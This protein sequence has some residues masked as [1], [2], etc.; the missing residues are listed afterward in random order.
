MSER[1]WLAGR[2][3]RLN[4][5]QRIA[6]VDLA[7]GLAV[8]GMFAAHLLWID[9][10][11]EWTDAATWVAVVDGR[12]SILFATLAGVSIGLVTGARTPLRGSALK[13]ARVRLAV[14]ALLLWLLG[15]LLILT[16]VPVYVILP[17]Y[18]LLFFLAILLVRLGARTLLSLSALLA[19]VMPVV[20]VALDELPLWN[21]M[22]GSTLSLAI[23]WHY[24]FTTWIAFLVAGLGVARAGIQRLSVQLWMLGAGVALAVVGYGADAATGAAEADER[25]SYLGALWTARP[26]STGL[27]EVVG[28]GGFALAVIGAAL[29][30]CRTVLVW[31]VLPLRA[32]G[33]MPLTA[34]TA[35]LLVWAAIASDVLGDAG[36]LAGFRDLQPF[37]PLTLTTVALCTAWALLVGRGPLEWAIDR[38][39]RW[40]ARRVDA[41]ERSAV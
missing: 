19:L 13:T 1:G 10:S 27:L 5:P 31:I 41:Q 15:L 2:W 35:Q 12:S 32:V 30:L 16:G 23:G 7:R 28:S 9:D 24:P 40:A 33:A 3:A 29:L 26:H 11:F 34:Y 17:A 6:G 36:D 20:Q 18:A 4:G 8:L 39:A 21:T 22:S 25:S 14:R 37:W 38:A